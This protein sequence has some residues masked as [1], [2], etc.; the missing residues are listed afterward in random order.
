MFVQE[1]RRFYRFFPFVAA[2]VK[3]DFPWKGF[4][5]EEGT[6][7]ILDLY[8]TNHDPEVWENHDVFNPN[9]FAKW[10]GGLYDFISQEVAITFWDIG[11]LGSGSPLK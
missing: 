7:T 11:V 3:K 5:F 8:G 6:L 4:K 2:V 10:E 9:R 1:V